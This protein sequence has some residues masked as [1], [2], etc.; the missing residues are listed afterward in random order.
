VAAV[1][2]G[3]PP[4][5]GRRAQRGEER[6]ASRSDWREE[7]RGEANPID[8]LMHML[9]NQININHYPHPPYPC[10]CLQRPTIT[11]CCQY[12]HSHYPLRYLSMSH[13]QLAIFII[14][15]SQSTTCSE[16]LRKTI[17]SKILQHQDTTPST[18]SMHRVA[19]PGSLRLRARKLFNRA[20]RLAA[21]QGEGL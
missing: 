13:C 8:S 1:C 15:T 6:R 12:V 20:F 16:E 21:L 3:R 18:G 11:L 7:R 17:I 10:P 5:G 9:S 2:A 4:G 19:T 14:S